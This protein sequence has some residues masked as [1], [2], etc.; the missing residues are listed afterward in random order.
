MDSLKEYTVIRFSYM[1]PATLLVI[2]LDYLDIIHLCR[3]NGKQ[4]I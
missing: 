2:D 4:H 1:I 3:Y